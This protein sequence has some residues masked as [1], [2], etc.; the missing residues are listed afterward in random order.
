MRIKTTAFTAL[1]VRVA[2]FVCICA[3]SHARFSAAFFFVG[4]AFR[5]P[6][7]AHR[8]LTTNHSQDLV[9]SWMTFFRLLQVNKTTP[10]TIGVKSMLV[11]L[12]ACVV[13]CV[14]GSRCDLSAHAPLTPTAPAQSHSRASSC[15]RR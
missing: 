6:R 3:V 9:F 8:S 13:A 1:A 12:I 15:R 2:W 14:V 4:C 10:G 5:A 11:K 7:A